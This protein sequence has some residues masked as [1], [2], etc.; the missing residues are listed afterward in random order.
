MKS[1]WLRGALLAVALWVLPAPASADT[2]LTPYLGTTFGAK[3]G[4]AEPAGKLVY[5]VDLMWLGTSGLGFELDAAF[6]PNFFNPADDENLFD[7]DSDGNVVSLMG[8]LVFGYSGGGVQPYVTGGLGLM[9]SNI[10]GPLDV[11]DI[12]SNAFGVN[13]GAGLRLGSGGFGIRGDVRY[14][15]QLSDIEGLPDLDLGD[16]SFW[17]ASVGLSFGF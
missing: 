8:N 15:R 13:V 11:F 5:G 6:S 3:F 12:D 7:F 14:F 2:F 1:G 4:D 9:R 10:D 16:L 17:R